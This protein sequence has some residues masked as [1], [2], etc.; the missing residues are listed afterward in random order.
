M[1]TM[2][3]EKHSGSNTHLSQEHLLTANHHHFC[4][5]SGSS[6]SPDSGHEPPIAAAGHS[7]PA[8]VQPLQP[9]G[10]RASKIV[11]NRQAHITTFEATN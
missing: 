3:G 4:S 2:W 8:A 11:S 9:T 5:C 6:S 7:L 1:R 10:V